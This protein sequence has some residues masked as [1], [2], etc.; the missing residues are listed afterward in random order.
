MPQETQY[1]KLQKRFKCTGISLNASVDTLPPGKVGFARN[2]RPEQDNTIQT[3][4]PIQASQALGSDP[5]NSLKTLNDEISGLSP[6]IV[7]NNTGTILLSNPP[8]L[9]E[10]GNSGN[11]LSFATY[12]PLQALKPFLYIGDSLRT[13]KVDSSGNLYN[14]GIAP[15]AEAPGINLALSPA[16]AEIET[17]SS[18]SGWAATGTGRS[19]ERRVGKEG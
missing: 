12:Q 8:A 14:I 16:S 18:T 13:R 15:P 11:P 4:P 17:L 9:L 6:L 7:G 1:S 5:L 3:R 2:I 19:E 10:L